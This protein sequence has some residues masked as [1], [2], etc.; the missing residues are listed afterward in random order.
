M[1]SVYIFLVTNLLVINGEWTFGV[2][3]Y[4]DSDGFAAN[5]SWFIMTLP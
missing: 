5:N 3:D 4:Q 2:Y 1:A